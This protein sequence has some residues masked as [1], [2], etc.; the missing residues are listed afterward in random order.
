MFKQKGKLITEFPELDYQIFFENSR[1]QTPLVFQHVCL[2]YELIIKFL[3]KL[4]FPEFV[5]KILVLQM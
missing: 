1:L 4:H 2:K 5:L 3:T